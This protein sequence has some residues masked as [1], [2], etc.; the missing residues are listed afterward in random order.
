[1]LISHFRKL[2][3]RIL[4]LM[5]VKVATISKIVRYSKVTIYRIKKEK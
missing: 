3:V 2:I 1:M 5:D 4:L